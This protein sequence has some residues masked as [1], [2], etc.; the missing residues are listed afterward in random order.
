MYVKKKEHV[1]LSIRRNRNVGCVHGQ[2]R[3]ISKTKALRQH[4]EGLVHLY[5]TQG[6]SPKGISE[7]GLA[8]PYGRGNSGRRLS[9]RQSCAS[10]V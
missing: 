9:A 5:W 8:T 6:V 2:R 1:R 3:E 4:T 10:I 7:R